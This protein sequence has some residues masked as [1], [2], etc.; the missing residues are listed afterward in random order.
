MDCETV[1]SAIYGG[2]PSTFGV[3]QGRTCGWRAVGFST[4]FDS[5]RSEQTSGRRTRPK[6]EGLTGTPKA[7]PG[8]V[9]KPPLR[10]RVRPSGMAL[11][12][13]HLG[14]VDA[15]AFCWETQ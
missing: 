2:A 13:S 4:A 10:Q 5:G 1:R 15:A 9:S 7:A 6:T 11:S 12:A 14:P 8:D 3:I